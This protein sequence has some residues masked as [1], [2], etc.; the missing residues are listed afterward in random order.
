[1][2]T[3]VRDQD[4]FSKVLNDLELDEGFRSKPYRDVVGKLTI[5]FGRNI[6]DN[7][8]TKPEARQLL[9]N[10]V[11][12]SIAEL[13]RNLSSYWDT[14]SEARQ[15]ALINMCFALGWPRFSKFKRM[16]S[17]L[18]A[19]D[20]DRAADEALDSK[21]ARIVGDRAQRVATLIREG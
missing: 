12:R 11:S 20:M 3:T 15:R 13:E 21:W 17:A 6:E 18:E 14:L 1:M 9:F 2:T 4:D 8:I 10:D 5:G 7:G 16:L 19:G